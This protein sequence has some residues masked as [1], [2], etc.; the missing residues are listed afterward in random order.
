MK[1]LVA[2]VVILSTVFLYFIGKASNSSFSIKNKGE[3][4]P[5]GM[6]IAGFI[7][8][9]AADIVK[10]QNT[11]P[12]LGQKLTS[13]NKLNQNGSSPLNSKEIINDAGNKIKDLVSNAANN[14]KDL[15]AEKITSQICPQ[16]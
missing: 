5:A 3:A 16:K 12:S 15:A 9:K 6:D 7:V 1:K 14:I 4:V 11:A 8:K 10:S 13:G 2:F